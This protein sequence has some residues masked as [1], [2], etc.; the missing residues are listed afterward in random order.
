[1]SGSCSFNAAPLANQECSEQLIRCS[2]RLFGPNRYTIIFYI[3]IRNV[4][5]FL[6]CKRPL[7]GRYHPAAGADVVKYKAAFLTQ[8]G[9]GLDDTVYGRPIPAILIDPLLPIT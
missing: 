2:P 8:G 4:N 6:Y 1:M 7:N 5:F 9:S 3:S